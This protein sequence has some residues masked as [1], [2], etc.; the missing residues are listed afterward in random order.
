MT[1]LFFKKYKKTKKYLNKDLQFKKR[2]QKFAKIAKKK[3]NKMSAKI[4]TIKVKV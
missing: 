3:Q 2:K 1:L 4:M